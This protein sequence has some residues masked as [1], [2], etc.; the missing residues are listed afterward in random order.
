VEVSYELQAPATLPHDPLNRRLVDP[1]LIWT[2]QIKEQSLAPASISTPDHLILLLS[3]TIFG[4]FI[5]GLQV[6][7]NHSCM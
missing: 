6:E 7:T 4:Q 1:E 3:T 5:S 2:L